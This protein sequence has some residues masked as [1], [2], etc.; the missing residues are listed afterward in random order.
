MALR[1]SVSTLKFK[2]LSFSSASI[3]LMVKVQKKTPRS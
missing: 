2:Q 1:P 3:H